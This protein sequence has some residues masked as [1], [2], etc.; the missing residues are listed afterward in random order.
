MTAFRVSGFRAVRDHEL[1]DDP[2]ST[3]PTDEELQT[4]KNVERRRAAERRPRLRDRHEPGVGTTPLTDE[5]RADFAVVRGRAR[6]RARRRSST[7]SSATSRT[8]TASG[9]RSSGSTARA[10]RPPTTSTLLAQTYDALKAVSAGRRVYGGA[11][12]PRGS[13]RP[14]ASSDALPD[15]VHRASSA[16]AYRASGRTRPVHG[17]VRD[18]PVRRQLEPAADDRRIRTRHVDRRRAT[19]TSS[20]RFSARRSTAPRSADRRCRSSTASTESRRRSPTARP[21]STRARADD[22]AAGQTRRRRPRYYEQALALSFCQ[23]NVGRHAPLP[24]ARRACTSD[25]AVGRP[26]RRR[27]PEV[28]QARWSRGALDRTTGGSI[29]RCPGVELPVKTS[30][31]RFGTRSAAKRGTF[32][33]SFRCDLDCRYW[34]RLEN[35]DTRA[36]RLATRGSAVVGELVQADLGTTAPE[37]RSIPLHAPPRSTR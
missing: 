14:A 13:D 32:R 15:E 27:H 22:D 18:P 20:S 1:L 8:S 16:I 5:A 34:V 6:P 19:T 33:A 23:P 36:T 3:K 35:A 7:S 4:S 9:S 26:L 11:V 2:V 37:A 24:V 30:Y 12:S 29:A 28:E 31:L 10:P 17:R 25:L 21:V